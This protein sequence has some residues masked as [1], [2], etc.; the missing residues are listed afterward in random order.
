MLSHPSNRRRRFVA[1]A[2]TAAAATALL[3]A[4]A[5]P[6][7]AQPGKIHNDGAKNAIAGSYIVVFKDN[8]VS[9]RRWWRRY[10]SC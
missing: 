8:A 1:L 4:Q 3:M 10:R 2:A 6:A 7:A 5:G 9:R